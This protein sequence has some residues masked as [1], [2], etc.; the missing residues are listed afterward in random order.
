M[1]RIW[2]FSIVFLIFVTAVGAERIN[3]DETGLA[4]KGYDPV[5]YFRAERALQG[6]EEWEVSYKGARYLFVNEENRNL[7]Q[8]NPEAF[9]PAY[10]GYCAWA[11]SQDYLAGINPE[12]WTIRQNILY[13][14]YNSTIQNRFEANISQ[15][16]KKADGNW[17]NLGEKP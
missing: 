17:Q 8:E 1:K 15:L 10:G 2:L 14:N 13:L 5:A 7:F 3:V 12:A 6:S 16:I 9:L 4:I 11:V